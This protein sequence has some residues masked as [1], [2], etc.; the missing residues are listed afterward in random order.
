[1]RFGGARRIPEERKDVDSHEE[2]AVA[3][4]SLSVH[5]AGNVR[6]LGEN[7]WREQS[8]MSQLL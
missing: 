4:L 2:K 1:M 3:A 7:S 8:T 5:V 6:M